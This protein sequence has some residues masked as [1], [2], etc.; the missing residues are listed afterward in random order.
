MKIKVQP[1]DFVV[2]EILDCP[3]K[4]KGDFGLYLLKKRAENTVGVLKKIAQELRLPFSDISYGGRKD[5]HSLS[6]Q[7]ITIQKTRHP[8]KIEHKNYSLQF[9][10]FL[11]RPMGPTLIKGNRFFITIRDLSE[12]ELKKALIGLSFVGEFGYTNYFDDQRFG[13]FDIQQ[14]FLADK[15]LKNH[16][17]GALKIFLTRSNSEDKREDLERKKKF[18]TH[19]GQWNLCLKTAVLGYEKMSFS[20]LDEHPNGF[21]FL[22]RKIPHE[23]LTLYFSAYQAFLWNE[24]SRRTI[25]SK[26]Q[27]L[28]TYPGHAGNY[29]F[30]ET[31]KKE[32]F[33]FLRALSIPTPA[34][35]MN[36]SDP[37]IKILYENIFQENRITT[38]MFNLTKIRQAYFKSIDR[39]LIV[40]PLKL[41]F[42]SAIDDLYPGKKKLL[43][44]FILPRGSYA[45]MLVKR[46]FSR[47]HP[48]RNDAQ[49][50]PCPK[51]V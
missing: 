43:V 17:N 22:L 28:T 9:V 47:S 27:T 21:L 33:C 20:Y 19:W 35:R 11:D 6:N 29:L 8:L 1:Q 18:Y 42:E 15:I 10:G 46:I 41:F 40:I 49:M 38:P 13:S 31:I 44:K 14:G 30:Y 48:I 23:E 50:S 39:A 24:A 26:I 51:I 7:Y 12:D 2:E 16:Y 45:T 4:K 5:R 3:I 36:L 25:A 32:E 37:A 34:S